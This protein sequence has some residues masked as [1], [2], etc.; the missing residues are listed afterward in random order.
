V[1]LYATRAE[2][3]EALGIAVATTTHDDKIDLMLTA[4]SIAFDNYVGHSFASA[5]RTEY[6]SG[7]THRN[8][9]VLDRPVSEAGADRAAIVV[10]ED[11]EALT[12]DVDFHVDPYPSRIIRRLGGVAEDF[13]V[14][15]AAGY[16]NVKITYLTAFATIPAD[17]VRAAREEAV[18][19][20]AGWNAST[21]GGS[22]IG[23]DGV[24]QE[25]G[26]AYSYA[27]DDLSPGTRR[28]LDNYL[29]GGW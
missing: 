8:A 15:F 10:T 11:G 13:A 12:I 23:L 24:S 6:H 20:F 22:R 19:A 27:V 28:T 18:R 29:P 21:L 4:V 9:I 7:Y 26:T 1:P 14:S 25:V 3:K 2:V 5:S 17:I 16:R